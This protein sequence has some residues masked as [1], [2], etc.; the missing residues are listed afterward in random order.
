MGSVRL[1]TEEVTMPVVDY[2]ADG[3]AVDHDPFTCECHET[4]S[5]C[6]GVWPVASLKPDPN[7]DGWAEF[8]CPPCRGAVREITEEETP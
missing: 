4:C 8:V 1:L 3:T 6:T 7:P 2:T 5:Y